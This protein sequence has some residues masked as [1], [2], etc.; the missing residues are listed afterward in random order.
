VTNQPDDI[1]EAAQPPEV[2]QIVEALQSVEQRSKLPPDVVRI[3]PDLMSSVVGDAS[4]VEYRGRIV[5]LAEGQVDHS[6]EGSS[7]SDEHSH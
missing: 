5:G 1:D 6:S 2:I 4:V 3:D 7:S